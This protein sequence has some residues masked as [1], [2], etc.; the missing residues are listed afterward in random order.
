MCFC[1][2]EIWRCSLWTGP[3]RLVWI[4][5]TEAGDEATWRTKWSRSEGEPV[6]ES[7]G[8][9]G[10]LRLRLYYRSWIWQDVG[11]GTSCYFPHGRNIA[12]IKCQRSSVIMSW[13]V[14]KCLEGPK[15]VMGKRHQT[16]FQ[17]ITTGLFWT[18][19]LYESIWMARREVLNKVLPQ[20]RG[21][22]RK[23]RWFDSCAGLNIW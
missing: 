21:E 2:R 7:G 12:T 4:R 19:A 18:G 23:G 9:R 10:W 15:G 13:L 5:K 14:L 3:A 1:C 17:A 11:L 16:N 6:N 20:G 8:K 22:F